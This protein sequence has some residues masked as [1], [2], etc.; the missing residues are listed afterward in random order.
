MAVRPQSLQNM[1]ITDLVPLVISTVTGPKL[2]LAPRLQNIGP[3]TVQTLTA[4]LPYSKIQT[5]QTTLAYVRSLV[6]R[7][8]NVL[9]KSKN[10]CS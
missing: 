4:Y 3:A 6:R 9:S 2:V 5:T 8:R 7:S 10:H 1:L